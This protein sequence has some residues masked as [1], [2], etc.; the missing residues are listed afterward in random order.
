MHITVNGSACK[1]EKSER[2]CLN[3]N[4]HVFLLGFHFDGVGVTEPTLDCIE[5]GSGKRLFANCLP[6]D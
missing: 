5:S 3:N 6:C 2:F 1:N 4:F